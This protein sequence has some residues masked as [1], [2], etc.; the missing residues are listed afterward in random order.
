MI[1]PQT[2]PEVRGRA[3]D[4]RPLPFL[5]NPHV[6]TLL[7]SLWEG[8]VRPFASGLRL[9]TVDGG[10][11]LALHDSSPEGWRPGQ[12]IALLVHGLGGTH[13]SGY[14]RRTTALLLEH[15]VRV[16]R[17]DLRGCGHGESLSRRTY[18]GA[19]S[20]DVR[21]AAEEIRRWSPASPLVL[22]GFSLG[23]NIILKLAG[24]AAETPLPHL[25]RVVAV[26]PPIDL[27]RCAELIS[28]P[29]NRFYEAH[30][31]R[32][33]LRQLRRHQKHHKGLPR[34]RI[35]I[36]ATLRQ[37][38]DRYTA[39]RGGFADA[40]DYYRRAS[41]LQLV[42]RIKVPTLILTARDDPFIAV[43]PFE[44]LVVPSQI[45]VEIARH[46]GHLG[47]LGRDA[48]GG[49]RWAERR[50]VDWVIQCRGS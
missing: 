11:R 46:G 16:V 19:S 25:E 17:M 33:M 1:R 28:A 13:A 32:A 34:V 30:F 22:I 39:P 12:S 44:E 5:K 24:E 47:F 4:F 43:E 31:V 3:R 49:V 48:S 9:A 8:R 6:Q 21:A 18:N 27:V 36:G 20:S 23:G 42:P 37:F 29:R 38:D 7:G 26:A 41:S 50:I 40:L 15:S 14:M 45:E 35:P 2:I 10:D